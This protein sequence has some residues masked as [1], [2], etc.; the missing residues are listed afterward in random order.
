MR[1]EFYRSFIGEGHYVFCG[2]RETIY[3]RGEWNFGDK[4]YQCLAANPI[5]ITLGGG[6]TVASRNLGLFSSLVW[7]V[8]TSNG[9]KWQ[10]IETRRKRGWRTDWRSTDGKHIMTFIRTGCWAGTAVIRSDWSEDVGVLVGMV[11]TAW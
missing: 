5:V 2:I 4:T 6:V 9:Q 1:I 10:I 3:P 8:V 11:W 7:T